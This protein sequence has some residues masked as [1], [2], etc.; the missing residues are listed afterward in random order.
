MERFHGTLKKAMRVWIAKNPH[1]TKEQFT[2]YYKKWISDY[3]QKQYHSALGMTPKEFEE[4][5][6]MKSVDITGM[7]DEQLAKKVS[8]VKYYRKKEREKQTKAIQ[9]AESIGIKVGKLKLNSV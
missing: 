8:E 9:R 3:N 7:S 5:A 6:T 2:E 4:K 1:S